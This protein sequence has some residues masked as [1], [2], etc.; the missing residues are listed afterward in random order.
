KISKEPTA[1]STYRMLDGG[2][3]SGEAVDTGSP[4]YQRRFSAA[5]VLVSCCSHGGKLTQPRGRLRV[6]RN[7]YGTYCLSDCGRWFGCRLWGGPG[8]DQ[9]RRRW[10]RGFGEGQ[11]SVAHGCRV[12]NR[13]GTGR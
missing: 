9:T 12:R 5:M 7:D 11:R 8:K 6:R 4:A 2:R 13:C 1:T 10:I 3:G